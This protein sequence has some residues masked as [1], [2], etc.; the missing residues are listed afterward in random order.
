[1]IPARADTERADIGPKPQ[2]QR[3]TVGTFVP[4]CPVEVGGEVGS[5]HTCCLQCC[6]PRLSWSALCL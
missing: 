6:T 5:S 2:G 1:M 3:V 4:G